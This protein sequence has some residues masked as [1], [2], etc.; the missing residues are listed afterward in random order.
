[1]KPLN[2]I[3]IHSHD[4][5]RYIQPYGYSV[6]SPAMQA[7]A[8]EGV[9]FRNAFC[10]SPTCSPSRAS[11][12]TGQPAHCAGM[13]DL[14]HFGFRLNDY[15]EHIL[16]TLRR[17]GYKSALFGFQHITDWAAP[18]AIGY[19]EI[20]VTKDCRAL[21]VVPMAQAYLERHHE[22]PFFLDIGIAETHRLGGGFFSDAGK[23][24][25]DA[26]YCRP[27]APLPDTLEIRQDYADYARAVEVYD[28]AVANLM[29]TLEKTGLSEQTLVIITTDHGSPFPN[30]KCSLSDQGTGV[31]LMMRGPTGSVFRGGKVIDAI[32]TQMDL[33][34]T[35]C[36]LAGVEKPV[37]LAGKSLHP[38]VA[39]TVDRL[40]ESI[41]F[42]INYHGGVCFPHRS[43]RTDRYKLIHFYRELAAAPH[44]CD[45][46]LSRELFDA[47]DWGAY[48]EED[49]QL[50]DLFFD[51]LEQRNLAE[52]PSV[53]DVKNNLTDRLVQWQKTTGD[54]LLEGGLPDRK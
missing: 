7:F 20:N 37:W 32:V 3:Y 26:R 2:I 47:H 8:E 23:A 1:M 50:Y 17:A 31:M 18:E 19:D 27:P 45:A 52:N 54:P 28:Q 10:Q 24:L 53:A 4:T 48:W 12:L 44:C 36:E 14:A 33:F 25:G 40:H 51:P 16:H 35:L 15:S 9:L 30:M 38:L 43:I 49:V 34:P 29:S 11:L 42:E 5:G 41:F 22:A 13:Y 39:G 6:K 21:E 46:G